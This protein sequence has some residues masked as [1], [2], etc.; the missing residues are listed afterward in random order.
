MNAKRLYEKLQELT[1]VNENPSEIE[2]TKK[3]RWN[4]CTC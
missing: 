1:Q 4:I 2:K 3:K